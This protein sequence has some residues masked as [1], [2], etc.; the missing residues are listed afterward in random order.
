MGRREYVLLLS[1]FK[2]SLGIIIVAFESNFM[3]R[4][5]FSNMHIS[6]KGLVVFWATEDFVGIVDSNCFVFFLLGKKGDIIK[7]ISH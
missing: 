2:C 3:S 7:Q 5:V 6:L 1:I 4:P